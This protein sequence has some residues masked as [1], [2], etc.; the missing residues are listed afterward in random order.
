[1][2][3]VVKLRHKVR[4]TGRTAKHVI[5]QLR[6]NCSMDTC[7]TLVVCGIRVMCW[8]EGENQ[9]LTVLGSEQDLM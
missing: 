4:S 1:M 2:C 3:F 7:E 9:V 8:G 5:A 6:E